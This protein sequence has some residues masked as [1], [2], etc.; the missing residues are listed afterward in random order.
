MLECKQLNIISNNIIIMDGV[1]YISI[2]RL[3]ATIRCIFINLICVCV[4]FLQGYT[5]FKGFL[6]HRFEFFNPSLFFNDFS[7]KSF[8]DDIHIRI[9]FRRSFKILNVILFCFFL[10]CV[11]IYT[12]FVFQITLIPDENHNDLC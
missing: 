11:I 1:K 12:T 3:S 9:L 7:N 8:E 10:S 2:I 5:F 6:V 4:L